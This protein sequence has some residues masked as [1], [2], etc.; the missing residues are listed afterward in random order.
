[1]LATMALAAALSAPGGLF[2]HHERAR[3]P[4]SDP[5]EWHHHSYPYGHG[6]GRIMPPGPGYGWGF[7]NGN[8][9]GYGWVDYNTYLPLG[10]DR[11][12]DYF[13]LRNYSLTAEQ[14]IPSTFYTPYYP[15]G[16]RY[17][18]YAAC[19]GDPPAGGPALDTAATPARPYQ[20][21]IGTRPL[22]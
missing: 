12:P 22:A 2:G 15:R 20:N 17:I 4:W 10:A 13:F 18:P 3:D 21:A 7:P 19:G 11:T 14:T 6:A 1:M 8:P 9:D 5:A 16:Q